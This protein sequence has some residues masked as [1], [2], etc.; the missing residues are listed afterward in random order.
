MTWMPPGEPAPSAPE[1]DEAWLRSLPDQ[2]LPALDG[3][4]PRQAAES[5]EHSARLELFAQE[6]EYRLASRGSSITGEML[7]DRLGLA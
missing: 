5:V 7:R 2:P 6:M 4:T 3:L 1:A